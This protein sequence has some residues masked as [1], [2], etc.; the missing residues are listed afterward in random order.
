MP[1]FDRVVVLDGTDYFLGGAT[2]TYGI[3][4]RFYAKRKRAPGALA[5]AREIVSVELSQSY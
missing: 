4:N 3:N 1:N 2:P 5:Q